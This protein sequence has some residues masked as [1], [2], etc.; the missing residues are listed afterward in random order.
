MRHIA[1]SDMKISGALMRA[2]DRHIDAVKL[3]LGIED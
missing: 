2:D 3:L 1:V